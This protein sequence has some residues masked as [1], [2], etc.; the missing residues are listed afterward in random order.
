MIVF[1]FFFCDSGWNVLNLNVL[2]TLC[3]R[4]NHSDGSEIS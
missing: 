2:F 4:G 1:F 3:S